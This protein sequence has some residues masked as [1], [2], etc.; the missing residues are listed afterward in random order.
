MEENKEVVILEV[1]HKP[2]NCLACGG[3]VV[4]IL[5]GE[6]DEERGALIDAKGMIMGGCIIADNDPEWGCLDCDTM[7][8]NRNNDA[9]TI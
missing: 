5:Y 9:P 7:Y 4:P 8:I 1:E 3:K 2:S 6:P